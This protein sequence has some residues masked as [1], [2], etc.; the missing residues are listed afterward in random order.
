MRGFGSISRT[1]MVLLVCTAGLFVTLASIIFV[2]VQYYQGVDRASRDTDDF[3]TMT[4]ALATEHLVFNTREQL[5]RDLSQLGLARSIQ[6]IH[7]YRVENSSGI[8]SF[9]ASYNAPLLAPIPSRTETVQTFTG[10]RLEP[11]YFEA[12]EPIYLEDRLLGYV[13]VR[14]SRAATDQLLFN[15]IAMA[16]AVI[17]GSLLLVYFWAL[18]LRVYITKPVD[19][20]VSAMNRVASEKNYGLRL[21][22]TEL[23]ELNSL[24]QAFDLM[25][26]RIQQHIERQNIAERQAGELNT[27]LER[28][29]SERTDALKVANRELIKAL[30]TVHQYQQELVEAQKMSS[31]GDMVAGVAHEINTPVGLVITSTSILQDALAIMQGKFDEKKVTSSDFQ[32]FL[33]S[34]QENLTLIERNIQRTA[35]LVSRFQQLAMDQFADD[36]R[37]FDMANFCDDVVA[38]LH[39]RFPQLQQYKLALQCPHPLPVHGRPGPLNQVFIQLVQNSLQ[40]AFEDR[41]KGHIDIAIQL[42]SDS[43]VLR[44][45]YRDDGVGMADEVLRKAFEP[46]TTT[47]R[48]SGAAGLGL[49]FVYNLVRQALKGT[50]EIASQPNQGTTV[51]IE[52]PNALPSHQYDERRDI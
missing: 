38:A 52:L 25:L 24:A 28:Q 44:I 41:E 20:L 5:D 11:R 42:D 36:S 43:G 50:I 34:C 4:A 21:A 48:G 15:G 16:L 49:H 31:L 46:F 6:H 39:N 18:R 51:K 29:V 12:V 7:V 1:I 22:R 27:E 23:A 35:D 47:K 32:R 2:V 45:D 13:Y 37:D 14:A 26:A 19:Q 33:G 10:V 9:F 8:T 17:A 30:E 3:T 40:H